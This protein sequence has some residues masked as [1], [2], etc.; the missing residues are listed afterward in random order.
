LIRPGALFGGDQ[1]PISL[2]YGPDRGEMA[3]AIVSPCRGY[4]YVLERRWGKGTFV[5]FL[6]LNPSKADEMKDD[7]TVRKC[8]GFAKR[9]GFG[10]LLVGNLFSYRATQP[11]DL[12]AADHPIGPD[13]DVWLTTMSTRSSI[14][15]AA[16]GSQP[17]IDKRVAEVR[18]LVG[19]RMYCIGRTQDGYPRH[20]SRPAYATPLEEFR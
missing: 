1:V 11:A 6:M 4:R 15:V 13:C 17:G 12:R 18:Q 8:V 20:P 14:V 9:W 7:P 5:M 2:V 3:G 16:W 19:S 10:G